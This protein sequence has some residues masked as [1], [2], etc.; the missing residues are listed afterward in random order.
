MGLE[1]ADNALKYLPDHVDGGFN[2]GRALYS[3]KRYADAEPY[4]KKAVDDSP[5]TSVYRLTLAYNYYAQKRYAE[6]KSQAEEILKNNP[7]YKS[8]TQL[9][10][11]IKKATG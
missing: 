6:A 5:T 10:D 8:A 2:K 9:L 7:N 11:D 1:N 4:L 3:L